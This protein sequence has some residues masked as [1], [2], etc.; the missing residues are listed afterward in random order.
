MVQRSASPEVELAISALKDFLSGGSTAP[1]ILDTSDSDV[2][3]LVGAELLAAITGSDEE[4][5]LCSQDQP[6][7]RFEQQ[8]NGELVPP[9]DHGSGN[10]KQE[11]ARQL[12][13]DY[14]YLD[15]AIGS[16]RATESPGERADA[17]RTLGIV[18][19]QRGTASL[20]AA[21]FD[22]AP[23]VRKAAEE[24][25]GRIGDPSVS[26]GPISTLINGDL[27]YGAPYVVRPSEAETASA[28]EIEI[29]STSEVATNVHS[30][31][32]K[33]SLKQ[34]TD[35][36]NDAVAE[37]SPEV[38]E[39]DQIRN[40][41]A[42]LERLL[43][44]AVAARKE[45]DNEASARAEQESAFRAEAAARRREDEETRK[46]AEEK[47]ARRRSEDDRK[48]AAEQLGRL[49]AELEAQRLAEEEERLR[50]ETGSLR[51]TAIEISRQRAEF[52]ASEFALAAEARRLE[53]ETSLRKAEEQCN[54]EL[55]RLRTEEEALHR[56]TEEATTQ[57]IEVEAQRREAE[58]LAL[59]LEGEKK[60]LAEWIASRDAESQHLR[61]AEAQVRGA[62]EELHQ[63]V[64][65]LLRVSEEVAIRRAEIE[66]DRSKLAVEL[67]QLKETQERMGAD[68][69]IRR[70]AETERLQ[71][72]AELAQQVEKEQRLLAETRG[73]AD[74]E[75]RRLK[76]TSRLRA[77]E[78]NRRLAEL[79]A[80]RVEIEIEAQQRAEKERRLNSEIEHLRVAEREALTRIGEV[81]SLRNRAEETHHLA[82]EKVQRIEAEARRQTMEDQRVLDKLEET[83]RNLDLEAHARAKHEKD[84][85]E[86]IEAL[87]KL[88]KEERNRIAE[89]SSSRAE[90][91][92]RLHRERDRLKLEEEALAK[93]ESE[94]E[95]LL[96]RPQELSEVDE[97]YDDPVDNLRA[98]SQPAVD[99][100]SDVV[101][102]EFVVSASEQT[103]VA[104]DLS[105]V[106]DFD[107]FQMELRSADP[108]KRM[109][110]LAGLAR[111]G[112]GEAFGLIASCFDDLSPEVR[113]AAARALRDR[114]PDR[115]VESFT[116]AIEEGSPERSKN[117]G[118]AIA[119]SGLTR[120]ALHNLSAQSRE[121]TYKAL[122]LLFVM[123]KAGE[124]QPLVQAIEEHAEPDVCI[125]AIKLLNLSGQSG[126][127]DAAL[128]RR[129]ES[130]Q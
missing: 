60:Q 94:I 83:R 67:E 85:K 114:E 54:A 19:S 24:A 118:V 34:A 71:L 66:A 129:R 74:G 76:E 113:N 98:V 106:S 104:S 68:E 88:E 99:E 90:A 18:G 55:K 5:A 81:E 78:H 128:Q 123:A 96:E 61:E 20:I 100:S 77:E 112:G 16:L 79:E 11:R 41:I 59:R 4:A 2:R 65:A 103:S 58:A 6:S 56:A 69:R 93:A 119:A 122:S 7:S 22:E 97:W 36:D 70:Q 62:Q 120:E 51:Q 80:L 102:E 26:I 53:A 14:G 12:F 130:G 42:E 27:D 38:E 111:H 127:A 33:V 1:T 57:R 126:A 82:A 47:A 124:I 45:A 13:I 105:E 116:R 31:A 39:L 115:T 107:S 89:I 52:E 48:M 25:L 110:G 117:I 28:E 8:D 21:L 108:Y 49:Q 3:Q 10:Q 32:G 63:Q 86:E 109:A 50:V 75:Q 30:V 72:E 17:A 84:L 29:G 46:R 37:A 87:R 91:E 23:E 35:K 9:K 15:E 101:S 40:N 43:V 125:A 44:D 121:D 95:F 92:T 73:R 64:E